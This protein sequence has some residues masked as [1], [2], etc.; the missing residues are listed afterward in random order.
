MTDKAEVQIA[1]TNKEE[2]A[3]ASILQAQAF[4]DMSRVL[5]CKGNAD[6]EV[7]MP[8]SAITKMGAEF[9]VEKPVDGLFTLDLSPANKGKHVEPVHISSADGGKSIAIERYSR[10]IPPVKV[11]VNG[12]TVDFDHKWGEDASCGPF[13]R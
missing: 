4:E 7:Y 9:K 5:T 2:T 6:I 8:D 1:Q 3:T 12:G 11:P 10:E 13:K